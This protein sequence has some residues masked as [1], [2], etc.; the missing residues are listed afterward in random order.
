MQGDNNTKDLEVE[1]THVIDEDEELPV[2][3]II[4]SWHYIHTFV[5][6]SHGFF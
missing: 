4:T 6:F 3:C 5:S 1:K 2:G